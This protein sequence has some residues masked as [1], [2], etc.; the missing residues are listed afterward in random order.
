V[1]PPGSSAPAID[2]DVGRGVDRLPALVDLSEAVIG[3]HIDVSDPRYLHWLYEGSPAG[4]AVRASA[5]AADRMIAHYAIV[6]V[7]LRAGSSTVVAGLGVNALARRE[8]QPRGLFAKLVTEVDRA[9]RAAGI[10]TTY[11]IPGPESEP[12]FRSVLRYRKAG[13]LGLFVRPARLEPVLRTASG[14]KR[15]LAPLAIPVDLLLAAA[16]WMWRARRR[17]RGGVIRAVTAFGPEF[18]GLWDRVSPGWGLGLVR[19]AAFLRWRYASPTRA[20]HAAAAWIDER[21]VGYVVYRHKTTHHRPGA[22]FGS[23]VDLVAERSDDGDAMAA[24]LVAH[25]VGQLSAE[26]AGFGLC[27]MH[28]PSRL[29]RALERNGFWLVRGR[30]EAS[31]PVMMKGL[32]EIASGDVHLTGADYD[33]G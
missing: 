8:S 13:E 26:G 15:R 5:Y 30:D 7:R 4:P 17:P 24:L 1:N 19:D 29:S 10:A 33:M 23:I 12:W 3:P 16:G 11:A 28:V 9:A 31:R 6:P 25:A 27:Q 22:A 20:Y 21:L 2:I 14:W 32:P 18:D